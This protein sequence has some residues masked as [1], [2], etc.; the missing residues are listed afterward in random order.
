MK[1]RDHTKEETFQLW[2]EEGSEG[3]RGEGGRGEGGREGG[4]RERGREGG[5]EGRRAGGREEGGRREGGGGREGGREEGGREERNRQIDRHIQSQHTLHWHYTYTTNRILYTSYITKGINHS[6][7]Q[8]HTAPTFRGE[9]A[10]E[11]SN[12]TLFHN[13]L[14]THDKLCLSSRGYL[15][16]LTAKVAFQLLALGGK[17]NNHKDTSLMIE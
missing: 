2:R 10:V 6:A 11:E 3:G 9:V 1:Q 14:Q 4:G 8:Y 13:V 16:S 7:T 5:R 12:V 15:S 17:D